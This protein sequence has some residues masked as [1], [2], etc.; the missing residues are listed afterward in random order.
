MLNGTPVYMY[1][2]CNV[3]DS[4]Q[5]HWLRSNWIHRGEAQLVFVQIKFTVRDC[6]SFQD[7]LATCK[8]TFNLY[9]LESD[10]DFGIHFRPLLFQRIDTIAPDVTFTDKDISAS[11][12]RL[13]LEVRSMGPLTMKGFYLAFQNFGACVALVSV[14][15]YYLVCPLV[16]KNLAIFPETV[17]GPDG[18]ME[19]QGKCVENADPSG[20]PRLHCSSKGEWLVP[21]DHCICKVGYE[22]KKGTCTA[23]HLGYYKDSIE[24]EKC[25]MCPANSLSVNEGSTF[26]PCND[27]FYRAPFDQL[28]L[29]C[30]KPPSCPLN[31]TCAVSGSKIVLRW[32]PPSDLGGRN[33][34]TYSIECQQCPLESETC[35]P[36]GSSLIYT[37]SANGLTDTVVQVEG[38]EPYTNYTFSIEAKNAVSGYSPVKSFTTV[39]VT[40]GHGVSPRVQEVNLVNRAEDSISIKWGTPK[41]RL[42]SFQGYEMVYCQKGEEHKYT[43]KQ[44]KEPFAVINGLLPGTTYLV[45]VR[46]LTLMEPGPY[47]SN[48]EFET[49]P[50]DSKSS[51]VGVLVPCLLGTLVVVALIVFFLYI[52][53]RRMQRES[54]EYGGANSEKEKVPLK[55]YVDL[56]AYEDANQTLLQFTKEIDVNWLTM[57]AVIGEGEFG[58][59]CHGFLRYPGKERITVA[60]KTLK[61][62]YSDTQ[63]WN[64]LREATI[65]GQFNHPNI[66]HLE[67]L[68]TKRK[69]MRIVTEFMENGAL[70][71]F[72]RENEGKFS[73][74]QLVGMLLGIASGMKYLAERNYVHR[75]LAARNILVSGSVECKVSDFGLSRIL[76]EEAG[77]T[78]E[79]QGGKIPIRWTAPEAIAY[80]TFTSAS[81]VWSYGIVMWEVLSYGDKPYG[82]MSNKEV[83]KNI[84]EGYRL[85]PPVDCPTVLYELMK[86]CWTYDRSKRPTFGEILSELDKVMSNPSNLKNIADFD[87]RVTL[88]LQSTSSE[89]I[90]YHCISEWLESIRMKRYIENFQVAGLDTME[91][92]LELTTEDLKKMGIT[93]PG[94]QKRILCS[95]QGFKE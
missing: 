47:S 87:P 64:F 8:E 28:S 72:L 35:E 27:G 54:S 49:L 1:E 17:S 91:S 88:R 94:H 5:E 59:V 63:W 38:L 74:L 13:N 39:G 12:V 23:C 36:C 52:R 84:E 31:A 78:Y 92:L 76:Q 75:D 85:P 93:M 45:R 90:P 20:T 80:R 68:V 55:P 42:G 95:I 61:S 7:D 77:G 51:V 33:D 82:S 81:D 34:V 37:P 15:V 22:E 25:K 71:A 57:D 67:G 41:H 86:C 18:L 2:D 44:L 46:V 16:T 21:V 83:M 24:T 50:G 53:R 69:P 6:K 40:F 4:D 30:T 29:P 89:G 73:P 58:E 48:Y 56:H 32:R 10:Q 70:D 43:V 62:T 9:Y 66:V 60:I 79:T 19:I 14:R 26:C 11:V 3:L 65:M